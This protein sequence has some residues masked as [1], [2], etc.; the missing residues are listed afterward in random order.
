[1][2]KKSTTLRDIANKLDIDVSTV[3]KALKNHPK[4]SDDTITKVNRV[5]D[6]L[7]YHP[8]NIAA[9]L[10][11]GKS[12]LLGVMVPHIDENFF[13]SAIRGIENVAKNGGY[14]VAIF[15]SNDQKEDEKRNLD[16]MYRMKVD[17]I[18]ASHAMQ[19]DTFDHY[20]NVIKQGIPLILFDRYN[21]TVNS[22]VVAIDDF[23]G[24]YEAVSHL[25]KQGCDKIAHMAGT[26]DVQIYSERFRGYKKALKD[27]KL[28]FD[29]S[30]VIESDLTLEDGRNLASH[31]L[32]KIDG[33]D[34]IFTSNDY[35]ALGAI[36]VLKEHNLCIPDDVAIVGFSNEN[37]TSFVTPTVTSVKQHSRK[38]GQVAAQLFLDQIPSAQESS[39]TIPVQKRILSPELIIRESSLKKDCS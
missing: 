32:D 4:I 25:I 29:D 12:N 22:D 1:M 38:M 35:A 5:A 20:Q 16:I 18:I 31:F 14:H 2:A 3:S 13:A 37:F 39:S 17:G 23:K 28:I 26:L 30:L 11:K 15:Q 8:N 27:N 6:E 19:A 21:D 7:N 34:A 10:V 36:Q 33:I 24:A 9:S